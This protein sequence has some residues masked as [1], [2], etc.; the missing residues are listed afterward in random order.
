MQGFVQI[1]SNKIKQNGIVNISNDTISRHN[2]NNIEIKP[3][4]V[5]NQIKFTNKTYYI[6]KD[7]FN[8]ENHKEYDRFLINYK[9]H[10]IEKFSIVNKNRFSIYFKNKPVFIF[11]NTLTELKTCKIGI[12]KLHKYKDFAFENFLLISFIILFG[13]VAWIIGTFSKYMSQIFKAII[14]YNECLKLFKNNNS[15]IGRIYFLL[16]LI[17]TCTLS[18]FLF[19][20]TKHF[21]LSITKLNSFE[22]MFINIFI[23]LGIYFFKYITINIIGYLLVKRDA[24]L[25]YLHSIYIYFKIIGL[26]ILPFV[27][28]ITF[29]PIKFHYFFINLGIIGIFIFYLFSLFKGIKILIQKGVLLFYWILYLCIVEIIPICLLYKF[30]LRFVWW[31]KGIN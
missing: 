17:F 5:I 19:Q 18:I 13:M 11:A 10:D 12:I 22:L 24:F 28:L 14:N 7:I 20:T 15:I 23:V 31:Q 30:V 4:E 6:E 29:L 3:K 27:L 1:D 25:E 8:N 9:K 16:N 21:N 2:Y 26:F